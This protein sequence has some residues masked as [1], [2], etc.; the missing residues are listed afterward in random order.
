[1]NRYYVNENSQ[2]T[3]EHEVHE[4]G[5]VFMPDIWNRKYLGYFVDA[6]EACKEARKLY[7]N[8]DGCY[9]CS[10]EAHKE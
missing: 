9:Y 1:M 3:G 10:R 8:V 6:K 7:S 4:E 2:P 5:C